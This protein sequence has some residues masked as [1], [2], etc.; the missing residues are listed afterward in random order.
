MTGTFETLVI[1]VVLAAL[2]LSLT[3]RFSPLRAAQQLGRTGSWFDHPEDAGLED[4]P[5]VN[6]NDPPIPQRRLRGHL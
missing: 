4:R 3:R 1:V 5:D 2:L 6:R